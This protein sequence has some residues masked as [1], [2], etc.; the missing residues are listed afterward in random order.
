MSFAKP[1]LGNIPAIVGREPP[2]SSRYVVQSLGK[3][4]AIGRGVYSRKA[5]VG[6]LFGHLKGTLLPTTEVSQDVRLFGWGSNGPDTGV[7]VE[8]DTLIRS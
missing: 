3:N 2:R 5:S 1:L 4:S 8:I 6:D 7:G